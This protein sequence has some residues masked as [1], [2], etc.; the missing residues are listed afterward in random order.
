L[1][2]FI[3]DKVSKATKLKPIEISMTRLKWVDDVQQKSLLMQ[4]NANAKVSDDTF[5]SE[6]GHNMAKEFE[7]LAQEVGPRAK[8]QKEQMK[9]QAEAEGEALVIQSRYQMKA[10]LEVAKAQRD[11]LA[12]LTGQGY[13]PEEAQRMLMSVSMTQPQG[14]QFTPGG[15]LKK[16]PNKAGVDGAQMANPDMWSGQF[17]S[18]LSEMDDTQRN[19]I[20]M[21]LQLQNPQLHGIV[22]QKLMERQGIDSRPNPEQKPPNRNAGKTPTPSKT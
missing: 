6:L 12:E 15:V 7:K 16:E 11:F 8:V 9:A 10:Q 4:A 19:M 13:S 3:I 22:M 21:K 17:A 2:R 14:G 18:T 20:L 1:I 5:V